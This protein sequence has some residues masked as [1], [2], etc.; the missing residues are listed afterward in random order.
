M[1]TYYD[2][3]G[4]VVSEGQIHRW[5]D[6]PIFVPNKGKKLSAKTKKANEK[7]SAIADG[8]LDDYW[9]TPPDERDK[10]KN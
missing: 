10:K 3:F 1:K 9:S 6:P 7:L 2:P 8:P 4:N 5:T